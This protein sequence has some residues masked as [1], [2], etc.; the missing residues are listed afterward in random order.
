M[1]Y[2]Y[3]AATGK[4][5]CDACGTPG[6]RKHRCPFGWCQSLALCPGCKTPARTGRA[7]HRESGCEEAALRFAAQKAAE[8]QLLAAGE[9]LRCSAIRT[10]GGTK[11]T[12]R[13]AQGERISHLVAS[14]SYRAIPLGTPA[15]PADYDIREYDI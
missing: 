13:N 3:E 11:V 6:A 10:E 1:G 15:T 4:L 9:F 2:C 12:F 5:C 8:E 14:E 7:A